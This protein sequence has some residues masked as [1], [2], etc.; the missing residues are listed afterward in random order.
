MNLQGGKMGG[1]IGSK[2]EILSVLVGIQG[3]AEGFFSKQC[4][5]I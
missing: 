1:R 2:T 4:N 5:G 3:T